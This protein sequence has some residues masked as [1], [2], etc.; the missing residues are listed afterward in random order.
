MQ[1]EHQ[2]AARTFWHGGMPG[3]SPGTILIPGKL[4]PGYAELFRNAPAE[5]LQILAQNWLYVT[6]DRDLA[7]DYAAQTGSL[8]GGGGLYRVEPFGQ[9]VPDP[10]YKHVSGISYRVKRAKV[11]ELEQEFDH[12]APYSPTGAALRYTMW[13]DGTHMYDDMGYPSPNAT[14]AALGVT[15]H[16]LRALDRGA[17]HIAI[18]EL[19][20]QLVSTRNPG[21]TQAQIDKIRAKHANRA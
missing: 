8:L 7:L 2:A 4:V 18:N 12:S 9:L 3:L 1:E 20:S 15:P 19:A 13:D 21:V 17:S 6:T 11:L 16:D 5:D 14:Q 10:D